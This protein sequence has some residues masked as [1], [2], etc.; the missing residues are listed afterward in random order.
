MA[1]GTTI[2]SNSMAKSG[3]TSP[4]ARRSCCCPHWDPSQPR[5]AQLETGLREAIRVGRLRPDARLPS[6]RAL[7]AELGV[8]RRLVVEAYEQL[9]AEGYLLARRGSGTRVAPPGPGPRADT[10]C[11]ERP[12]QPTPVP[13]RHRHR[14]LPRRSRPLAVPPPRLGTGAAPRAR[15][16]A[17]CPPRL[18]RVRRHRRA[19]ASRS[20]STSGG[21]ARRWPSPSGS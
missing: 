17:R 8:S 12:P 15:R 5:R 13:P 2:R 21:C 7:A 9:A 14:P 19:A 18:R 6:S 1:C 4:A 10:A 11:R 20:P 16:A 3:S